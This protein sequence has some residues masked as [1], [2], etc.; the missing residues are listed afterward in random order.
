MLYYDDNFHLS[1][2]NAIGERKEKKLIEN[3]NLGILYVKD[4]E[5]RVVLLSA[6]C[7]WTI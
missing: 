1:I 5:W 3:H 2:E 4:I 6:A 7:R